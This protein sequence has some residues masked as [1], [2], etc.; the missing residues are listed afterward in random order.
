MSF[1]FAIQ[2]VLGDEGGYTNEP[3]DGGGETNWGITEAVARAHGY[4][5]AMADLP[6]A[7]AVSIYESDYWAAGGCDLI[8]AVNET[9][10]EDLFETSVNIGISTAGMIL[11]R[12]LNAIHYQTFTPLRLDGQVGPYTR[13]ALS[14]VIAKRGASGAHVVRGIFLSLVSYRYVTI[15][16]ANPSQAEYEYGWELNRVIG[17]P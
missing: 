9:L 14:A 16:E 5:G 3:A 13:N 17:A 8:D 11:Q 10:G 4:D 6:R 2:L 1:D 15:A 12:A 7:T